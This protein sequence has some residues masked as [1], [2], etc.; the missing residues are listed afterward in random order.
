MNTNQLIIALKNNGVGVLPT[1]TIYGLVGS[2]LSEPAIGRM[3]EI[4]QRDF[5]K[6][7]GTVLIA[8]SA[9]IA[10][11]TDPLLLARAEA[12]WPSATSV[13]LPLTHKFYYAHGG[14]GGLPFRIPNNPSLLALLEEVGPLATTSANIEGQSPALTLEHAKR[15]FGDLPDFYVDGGDM[16]Q[17]SASRIIILRDDGSEQELRA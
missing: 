2:L 5:S 9:Q 11:I 7:I 6:P 13:L 14:K 16:S 4:K 17:R 12:Y 10:D 3:R 15:Y 1:D 8:N